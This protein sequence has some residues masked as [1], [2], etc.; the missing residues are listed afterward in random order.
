M[1]VKNQDLP[2]DAEAEAP[3]KDELRRLIGL[4]EEA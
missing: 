2:V 1:T 3:S 4:V